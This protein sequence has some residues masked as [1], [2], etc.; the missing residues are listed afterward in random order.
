MKTILMR[1][2]WPMRTIFL[3]KAVL[4]LNL[5]VENN[6]P[7]DSYSGKFAWLARRWS[8][9][10]L[11]IARS[12]KDAW[13][14]WITIARGLIIVLAYRTKNISFC[15]TFTLSLLRFTRFSSWTI[16]F[17]RLYFK[18]IILKIAFLVRHSYL[19]IIEVIAIL[20]LVGVILF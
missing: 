10:C 1:V 8:L 16:I 2:R 13:L 12:A 3:K 7:S 15:L 11:S 17:W 20:F 5:F 6:M 19:F 14:I 9:L 4:L 18:Q